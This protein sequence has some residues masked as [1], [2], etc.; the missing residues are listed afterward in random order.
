ME[1]EI[2]EDKPFTSSK[3]IYDFYVAGPFFNRDQVDSMER[4]ERVLDDRH[5]RMFRPRFMVDLDKVGAN[6]C[7]KQD[8]QGIQN[9]AAVIANIVDDDPGTLFEIGYAYSLGK[10]VYVYDEGAKP[11][12]ELNLMIAQ[13]ATVIF[14]GPT[15]LESF[16]DSGEFMITNKDEYFK[17]F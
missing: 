3:P 7:F 13:A 2:F 12:D 6:E 16:L 9:S 14:N 8:I 17:Q 5:R 1:N 11:G 10:P 4:L 15:D